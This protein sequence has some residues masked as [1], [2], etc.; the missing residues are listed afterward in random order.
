MDS[1]LGKR[2][3]KD[4]CKLYLFIVPL[5]TTT[6]IKVDADI[7]VNAAGISN[8]NI[9]AKYDPDEISKILRTNLEGA[10]LTSRALARAAVRSGSRNRQATEE[11]QKAVS[12][13]IINISSLLAFKDGRGAV[14]YAASKAGIL[15]LTRSLVSEAAALGGKGPILR[16]NVIVPGYIETPMVSGMF[17]CAFHKLFN[18]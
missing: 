10:I 13:C 3:G 18:Y 2:N 7:L 14:P 9:L 8:S 16:S 15:G 12:K 1:Q 17:T 4:I 5:M 6:Q 11:H